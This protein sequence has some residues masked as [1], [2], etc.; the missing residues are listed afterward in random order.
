MLSYDAMLALLRA[1]SMAL[2]TAKSSLTPEKLQQ[3][4]AKIRGSQSLQGVSGQI[5]FG[6][7]GAPQEKAVVVLYVAPRGIQ[8]IR[9]QEGRYR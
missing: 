1:S 6:Q 4:L 9:I 8:L 5:S 7:D 2:A 3:A